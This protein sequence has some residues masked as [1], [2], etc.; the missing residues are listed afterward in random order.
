LNDIEKETEYDMFDYY[1]VSN[2]DAFNTAH[3]PG[4]T[5][6]SDNPFIT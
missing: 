2:G 3:N 4:Y 6:A 5:P 1:A